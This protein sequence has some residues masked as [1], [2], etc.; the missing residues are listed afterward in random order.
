MG[1]SNSIPYWPGSLEILVPAGAT[2]QSDYYANV[3]A[4]QADPSVSGATITVYWSDFDCENTACTNAGGT[5]GGHWNWQITDAAFASWKAS[6][7]KVNIVLQMISNAAESSCP[8]SG[9]GS[10][11]LS[12]NGTTIVGNCAMPP[13]VWKMLG[14]NNYSVC[15]GTQ[16][17]PDYFNSGFMPAYT[18]AIA[19]FINNYASQFPGGYIRVA[20]G[21]GGEILPDPQWKSNSSCLNVLKGW[22]GSTTETTEQFVQDWINNWLKPMAIFMGGYNFNGQ[23]TPMQIMGAITPMSADTSDIE[24]PDAIAPIYV[25]NNM[26]FGSQGLEASDNSTSSTADWVNLFNTYPGVPLELQSLGQSCP[27]AVGDC[28][29]LTTNGFS[30]TVNGIPYHNQTLA[31]CTG[32]L[33]PLILLGSQNK[34]TVFEVYYRDWDLSNVSPYCTTPSGNGTG[35]QYCN[36]SYN[37]YLDNNF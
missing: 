21:H 17:F 6:G 13:W 15:G 18:S 9:I 14:S 33:P 36:A 3:A 12:T 1:W 24:V 7:K 8:S 10:R 22:S 32:P 29:T 35:N 4:M 34:A 2:G 26:G 30:C 5:S 16:R 25:S 37:G 20:L 31:G 23:K 11:G 28:G 19:A 27:S